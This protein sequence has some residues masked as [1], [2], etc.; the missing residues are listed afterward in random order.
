M[1]V[2]NYLT[3]YDV[4]SKGYSLDSALVT[5]FRGERLYSKYRGMGRFYFICY[6][7][8]DLFPRVNLRHKKVAS[9]VKK[10]HE[11]FER[12]RPRLMLCLEAITDFQEMKQ[13]DKIWSYKML[14]LIAPFSNLL[15]EKPY[16]LLKKQ[17]SFLVEEKLAEKMDALFHLLTL[18][19]HYSAFPQKI[20]EKIGQNQELSQDE[21]ELFVAFATEMKI[22]GIAPDELRFSL[23]KIRSLLQ[24]EQIQLP[25]IEKAFMEAYSSCNSWQKEFDMWRKNL[26]EGTELCLNGT[27]YTLG[28][29]LGNQKS[30]DQ[31]LT[32]SIYG[33]EEKVMRIPPTEATF[34]EQECNRK[35]EYVVPSAR[36]FHIDPHGRFALVEKLTFPFH[37]RKWEEM[38]NSYKDTQTFYASTKDAPLLQALDVLFKKSIEE[39]SWIPSIFG[40]NFH[41]Q[42][43]GVNKKG[44]IMGTNPSYKIEMDIAA[45]ESALLKIS[46]FK[47]EAHQV[48]YQRIFRALM[49][50]IGIIEENVGKKTAFQ[51]YFYTVLEK[52]LNEESISYASYGWGRNEVKAAKSLNLAIY[53]LQKAVKKAFVFKNTREHK[54]RVKEEIKKIYRDFF[55]MSAFPEKTK[56]T[57]LKRFNSL[58][59]AL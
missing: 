21:R 30:K 1:T 45:I 51:S 9:C 17:L 55:C 24:G 59:T 20:L 25:L 49:Q 6:A 42:K 19:P 44:H 8:I 22:R 32:F 18:C 39:R 13:E 50:G 41:T 10:T 11:A 57:L 54:E 33:E 14:R 12:I 38:K 48:S 3:F 2:E 36:I 31:F 34:F 35:N 58:S 5:D 37:E 28:K 23:R 26:K 16:F 53:N 29:A 27:Y 43:I 15:Y 52:T 40:K 47:G 7:L 46:C 4:A 56:D